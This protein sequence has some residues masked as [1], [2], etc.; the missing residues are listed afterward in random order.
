MCA[1]F[2]YRNFLKFALPK[3]KQQYNF[4][5]FLKKLNSLFISKGT[6]MFENLNAVE[7]QSS[8]L[9][10]LD[11][12]LLDIVSGGVAPVAGNYADYVVSA[13]AAPK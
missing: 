11:A 2:C 3:K 4:Y 10:E 5:G 8:N 7:G 12:T 1:I 9:V 6:K 13:Q